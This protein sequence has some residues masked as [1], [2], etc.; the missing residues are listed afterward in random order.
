MT[1]PQPVPE[2]GTVPAIETNRLGVRFGDVAALSEVSLAL[3]AG[4]FLAILGPNGSGKSTLLKVLLGLV[5]PGG[6]RVAIFG[7]APDAVP[8]DWIG[9]V[10]QVKTL[11]RTFPALA[12]ELVANGLRRG[13]PGRLTADEKS[14]ALAALER[15]G[16]AHLATRSLGRLSGGE[17]QRVYLARG[18]VRRPRLVVLD[19]PASGI[20][21]VG[22]A[23][24][25]RQLDA[26]HHETQAT[27]LM[28]THDWEAAYHHA[29]HVL[30]LS[31]RQVAFGTPDTALT[32]T[33][34]RRAFGHV[35]HD[36]SMHVHAD[37][38]SAAPRE[39]GPLPV[40]R[41]SNPAPARRGPPK[42]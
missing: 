38:H 7:R 25:Y 19:E 29:T 30:V 27:V 6:G 8:A 42:P 1:T 15:C 33:V 18:L 9:Y 28:V 32:D 26:Y 3:P 35:D 11:D 40:A 16:A 22:E 21:A 12:L 10:P 36:H 4:S 24:M 37:V 23:D 34:L 2:P 41:E 13:W 20:D 14:R 39:I 31:G 17:L 5:P